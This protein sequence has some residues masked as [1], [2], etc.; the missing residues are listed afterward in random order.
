MAKIM[1]IAGLGRSLVLFRGDLI[2]E[3]QNLGHEVVAA[4][5]GEEVKGD[6]EQWGVRYEPVPLKRAGLNPIKD[7]FL[8]LFLIRLLRREK[9]DYLFLYT[10]KPVIYG[11]LAARF[12]PAC[13]VYSMVTGLGY[14]FTASQGRT[15]ALKKMVTLLYR[16]AL[17]GNRR[18]FFQNSD[19]AG[20]F[21]KSGILAENKVALVNGSGVNLDY[22][23]RDSLPEGPVTFLLIA[24]LL[25]EKGIVEYV[26][27]ARMVKEKYPQAV[28]KMIGWPLPGD[29]AAIEPEL[30]EKWKKEGI[31]EILG[32]TDDVRPYIAGASVY[33]LPSYREGTPRTVLEAMAMGRPVIT[34]DAPGCRETVT[35]GVNGFL[36][37]VKDA[38]ALAEVMEKFILEPELVLS[39][40][41]AGRRIAED[42]YDVRKVNRVINETMGLL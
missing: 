14:A 27:A 23:Y 39:M 13:R 42:K 7:I 34:T 21:V 9:P 10:I 36:V 19:D 17:T 30:V 41:R 35:E 33:V 3:W 25:K 8:V 18:V 40:G 38:G 20:E 28:F 2:K 32:E 6:L 11:S 22:Y 12:L 37:P 15:G 1:I 31:V 24:R 26:E 16:V 4:A 29:P 5:P